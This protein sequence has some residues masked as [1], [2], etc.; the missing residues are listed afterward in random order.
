[1]AGMETSVD[2]LV[3]R[4]SLARV[5]PV[6]DARDLREWT[7]L[8]AAAG[9]DAEAA[10]LSDVATLAEGFS[11]QARA[12]RAGTERSG[13]PSGPATGSTL[14]LA[15]HE[16]RSLG[17]AFAPG[18]IA[19]PAPGPGGRHG[20]LDA[21]TAARGLRAMLE[22][23][24]EADTADLA[25]MTA[26]L[27]EANRR[28]PALD[29]RAF[30]RAPLG[31]LVPAIATVGLIDWAL[32]T[33]DLVAAPLGSPRLLHRAAALDGSGLGPYLGNVGRLVRDAADLFDLA[34]IA[35][36]A[37]GSEVEPWVALL[38]RGC[39]GGLLHQ[40]VDEL[41]DLAAHGALS[42]ILDRTGSHP[43]TVID[44]GLVARIRDAA[45]DI[46][47]YP[48]AA[49]AQGIIARLR[50]HSRLEAVILGTIEAS[51][52]AFGRAEAIF[53]DQLSRS[54]DDAD[55]RARL[56]AAQV[57]RFDAFRVARGFG[58][59]IDR[60]DTRLRR[61]GEHPGHARRPGERMYAA[62]QY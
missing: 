5:G 40:V 55:L 59:P 28:L 51:G 24:R 43:A 27:A 47:D 8:L 36:E 21:A 48:L 15:R 44:I 41:G 54:P 56:E 12:A 26:A 14:G 52:G 35:A 18:L 9:A 53:R 46:G 20:T 61:R 17:R 1:M 2:L 58:S 7:Q 25:A 42:A 37:G 50:P 30:A 32:A 31:L 49:R 45:L 16:L 29:F 3:W 33:R 57:D 19:P 34:R 38:S 62:E 23:G 11:P 13:P 10:L 4:E 60:Q 39:G 22:D 6:P